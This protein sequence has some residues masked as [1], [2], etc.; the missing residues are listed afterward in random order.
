MSVKRSRLPVQEE[1]GA[2]YPLQSARSLRDISTTR[3]VRQVV[4]STADY[5]RLR[6]DLEKFFRHLGRPY[7]SAE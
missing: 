2:A 3:P 1:R 7:N 6:H 5:G 4:I